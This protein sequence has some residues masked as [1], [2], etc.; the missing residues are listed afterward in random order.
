VP[1]AIFSEATLSYLGLGIPAPMA[2]WG[3]MASDALESLLVGNGYL[4]A[5]PAFLISLTMF[6][7]NVLGDG[8]RD[9]LDP[10]LRK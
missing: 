7:F 8:L 10:R 3:T 9:A 2:S 5:I 4:L 6:G 1:Q